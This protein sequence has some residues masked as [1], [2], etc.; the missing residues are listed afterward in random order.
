MENS[1]SQNPENKCQRYDC[2]KKLCLNPEGFSSHPNHQPHILLLL[3]CPV[4]MQ[5]GIAA[6]VTMF[7]EREGPQ[8]CVDD[9]AQ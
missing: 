2:H 5:S 7:S 4:K 9:L 1:K 3:D 8:S 6:M